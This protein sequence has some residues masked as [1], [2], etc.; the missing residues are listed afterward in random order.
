MGSVLQMA[1][2][3]PDQAISIFHEI[4]QKLRGF[5]DN[6]SFPRDPLRT[7]VYRI[8]LGRVAKSRG[9]LFAKLWHWFYW[10]DSWYSGLS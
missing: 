1:A 5:R 2:A 10:A 7:R 8:C 6:P 4:R 3:T 9:T